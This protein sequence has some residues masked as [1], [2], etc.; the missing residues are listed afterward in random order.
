[1]VSHGMTY[2]LAYVV[3]NEHTYHNSGILLHVY[4]VCVCT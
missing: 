3:L 2:N 1:M 4:P